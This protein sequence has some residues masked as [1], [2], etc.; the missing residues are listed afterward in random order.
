MR[1]TIIWRRI[2]IPGHEYCRL[3]ES[4]AGARMSGIA[5]V[6]HDNVPSYIGYEV[7]CDVMW[8]ALRCSVKASVGEQHMDLDIRRQGK[9]WMLNGMDAPAVSGAD[10]IDLGFSPSTNLL[11]I[12][13][14]GLKIGESAAVRAAWVKFPEFSLELL[15]QTYTRVDDTTYRYE[16]AGA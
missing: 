5:L 4:P 6:S 7:E 12:R 3:V 1:H 8:H 9:R 2:D 14:L 11:P 16:S 13:R 15:E 10:D